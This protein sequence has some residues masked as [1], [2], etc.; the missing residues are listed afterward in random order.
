MSHVSYRRIT[1]FDFMGLQI[2]ELT[3]DGLVSASVAEVEIAPGGKHE[4]AR[5][6]RSDKLYVCIEGEI[7]FRIEKRDIKLSP[8]D[9]LLIRRGE[10]FSYHNESDTVSR[11]ILI[12]IP[13]FDLESEEFRNSAK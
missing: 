5:S 9:V 10:W 11:V 12:H 1:P 2:R 8:R 6:T 13:P 7:L 4:M 3:P